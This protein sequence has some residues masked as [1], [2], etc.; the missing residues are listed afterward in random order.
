MNNPK[1]KNKFQIDDTSEGMRLDNYLLK[2]IK[3]VPKSKIYNIIRKGEVRV[4]SKRV[5]P[6]YKLKIDDLIR[7][8]PNLI[9]I[10][11]QKKLSIKHKDLNWIDD[12]IIYEDDAFLVLNKPS[13]IA[14][15]GGSGIS[16]GLIE[17][18]RAHRDTNKED[19]ELVHRLDKET[20]GCLLVSK[21]RS[22]LRLLHKYFRDGRVDKTYL[23]L[24]MGSFKKK[25]FVVDQPLKINR[26]NNQRKAVP[27]SDGKR[28]ITEF[29]LM[30]E[31]DNC[32][33]FQIK[34]ITGK[35]H[36]IRVHANFIGKP[37]AGDQRYNPEPDF[38]ENFGL[39]RLFL[40]AKSISFPLP[41]AAEKI[42][43]IESNIGNE[44]NDVISKLRT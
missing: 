1:E 20:S 40:H 28:A 38:L 24:L 23:G 16:N 33:L 26:D 29:N 34:P 37:L 22:K 7:I 39:K 11:S 15:H 8:P 32:A 31:F 12:I 9:K 25:S 35:T 4:N 41:N 43:T 17:L 36:Q 2:T 30:E 3:G 6:L 18:L 42:I 19:L 44:L 14:V 10:G 21:K 13:G 5:K 27:D